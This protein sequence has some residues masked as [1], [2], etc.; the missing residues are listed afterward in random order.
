M[1]VLGRP[2]TF[3]CIP[4]ALHGQRRDGPGE[5]QQARGQLTPAAC[6]ACR[7]PPLVPD[8]VT[9]CCHALQAEYL[10]TQIAAAA[11][12]SAG[13]QQR[14]AELESALQSLQWAAAQEQQQ[15]V[16]QTS[17]IVRQLEEA[18]EAAAAVPQL[19]AELAAAGEEAARLA[20]AAEQADA[21]VAAARAEA[22]R[23]A[24]G[25]LA[26]LAGQLEDAR[27]AAAQVGG[28]GAVSML[29]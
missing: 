29:A 5:A 12:E 22:E 27:A 28:L 4:S 26:D 21:R 9:S 2:L 10:E 6:T 24:M 13:W 8:P 11:E 23:E 18:Q 25:Q 19:R 20:A 17:A 14:A 7:R 16:D 1:V 15:L 3:P